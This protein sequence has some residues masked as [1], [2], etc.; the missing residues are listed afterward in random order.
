MVFARAGVNINLGKSTLSP[1]SR[2]T[3][4]PVSRVIYLGIDVDMSQAAAQVKRSIVCSVRSAMM[5]PTNGRA[6]FCWPLS[7]MGIVNL[8]VSVATLAWWWRQ[9]IMY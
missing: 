2:V 7:A 5:K 4:S 9:Y 8:S 3:L 6:W 1:V